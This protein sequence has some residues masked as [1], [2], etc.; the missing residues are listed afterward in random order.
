MTGANP[1]SA[2]PPAPNDIT[3]RIDNT[4]TFVAEGD[5][6]AVWVYVD[7]HGLAKPHVEEARHT[8]AVSFADFAVHLAAFLTEADAAV[9]G[10]NGARLLAEWYL[11]VPVHALVAAPEARS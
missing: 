10:S 4:T 3:E 9:T 7:R 11:D 2:Y 8:A 1:R 5:M 6:F